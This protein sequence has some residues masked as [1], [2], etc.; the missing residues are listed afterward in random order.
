MATQILRNTRATLTI[1]FSAGVADGAVTVTVRDEPGATVATGTASSLGLGVYSFVV[2]PQAQLARLTLEWAGTWSGIAQSMT[3]EAEIVGG[4]LF[5]IDEARTWGDLQL[6]DDQ[7]YPDA[8]IREARERIADDFQRICC[9]SFFP[10]YERVSLTGTWDSWLW[11]PY[12]F[13]LALISTSVDGVALSP[14]ELA[15]VVLEPT[16][17]INLATGWGSGWT[18][19]N[20]TIEWEHGWRQVPTPIK[21]AALALAHYELVSSEITDRQVSFANELGT[22]RLSTPGPRTPTGIPIVDATLTRFDETP[23]AFVAMR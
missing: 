9:V 10:R 18:R 2:D 4:H 1:D 8:A 3:T 15:T 23:S 21:R 11:L 19:R 20:V 6:A 22:V 16:G 5:T 13:P 17:R 12:K 7:A 14:A